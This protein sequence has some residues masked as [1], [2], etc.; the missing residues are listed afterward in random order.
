MARN[1]RKARLRRRT[2]RTRPQ[3]GLAAFFC[4]VLFRFHKGGATPASPK[5]Q[6]ISNKTQSSQSWAVFEANT[7]CSGGSG[8]S[9]IS[10]HFRRA[11][12]RPPQGRPSSNLARAGCGPPIGPERPNSVA[13]HSAFPWNRA[14]IWHDG[15][16]FA[17]PLGLGDPPTQPFGNCKKRRQDRF[18]PSLNSSRSGLRRALGCS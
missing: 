11:A 15:V 10:G 7:L 9:V 8:F 13:A 1:R 3:S 16:F 17:I 2:S 4:F 6:G 5:P 14:R 12:Q 18:G